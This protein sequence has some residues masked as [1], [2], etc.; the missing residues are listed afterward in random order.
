MPGPT[1]FAVI[2][3]AMKC[4]TTTLFN[5]LAALPEVCGSVPKEP[6]YFSRPGWDDGLSRYQ[7]L[8]P[9]YDP[10]IHRLALEGSTEYAKYPDFPNVAERIAAFEAE[11]GLSFRFIYIVRD[12][13]ELIRSGL[14]HGQN[15]GWFDGD[16]ER[17]FRHLV[18]VADFE[19][20]TTFYRETFGPDRLHIMQLEALTA[21]KT[22]TLARLCAFLEIDPPSPSEIGGTASRLN[23][24]EQRKA[25]LDAAAGAEH[26]DR[27]RALKGIYGKVVPREMREQL[28][29]TL[30]RMA[31]RV[32]RR[33][34]PQWRISDAEQVALRNAL[35][36]PVAQFA[37]RYHLDRSGWTPL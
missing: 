32:L 15:A 5:E 2:V 29:P 12:P 1:S 7:A 16:R 14:A 4:G 36:E 13:I 26:L 28:R 37:D 24:A 6:M 22:A 35:A 31:G 18:Q 27:L 9:D 21:D 11:H 19:Q 33:P 25:D 20:Q 34:E 30:Q 3:G 23:S 10:A 8:W 17:L